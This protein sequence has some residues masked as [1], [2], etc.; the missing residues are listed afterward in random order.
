MLHNGLELS[1]MAFLTLDQ[2]LDLYRYK[3][4]LKVLVKSIIVQEW[5]L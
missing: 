2:L 4:I 1:N 3:Y 5:Q